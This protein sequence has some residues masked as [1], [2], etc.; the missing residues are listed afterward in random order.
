LLKKIEAM[1]RRAADAENVELVDIDISRNKKHSKIQIVIDQ[2]EGVTHDECTAVSRKISVF[3]DVSDLIE[4]RYILEISS[5]GLDRE[6]KKPSDFSRSLGK[7][8]KFT[9]TEEI[10][11]KRKMTGR[12]LNFNEKCVKVECPETGIIQVPLEKIKKI[13]LEPELDRI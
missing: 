1:A 3:L 13:H 11:K 2:P 8:V 4:E 5:P 10:G 6:L 9:L 12:L 7:L